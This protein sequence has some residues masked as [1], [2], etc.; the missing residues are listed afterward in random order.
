MRRYGRDRRVT[1]DQADGDGY[2][3]SGW[4]VAAVAGGVAAALAVTVVLPLLLGAAA[5]LDRSTPALVRATDDVRRVAG[6]L[7]NGGGANARGGAAD[8]GGGPAPRTG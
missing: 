3:M 5:S 4:G 7:G 2:D 8:A 6:P 1:R